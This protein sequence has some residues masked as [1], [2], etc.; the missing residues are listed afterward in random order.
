MTGSL[1]WC[2]FTA[3]LDPVKGSEQAGSRPV[4]VVSLEVINQALPIVSVLPLTTRKKGRRVYPT[5]TLLPADVAGQPKESIVM[6]HQVRTISKRRLGR[7][8]GEITDG[9]LKDAIRETLRLFFDL[10]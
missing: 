8:Y 7:R 2:V 9:A 1:Q 10:E 6:A 3:D 4:L 5:E